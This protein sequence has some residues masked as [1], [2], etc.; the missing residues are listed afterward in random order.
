MSA[1]S[2]GCGRLGASVCAHLHVLVRTCGA[3]LR[4][5]GVV[6]VVVFVVVVVVVVVIISPS[7]GSV[8]IVVY[9]LLL[10]FGWSKPDCSKT[11]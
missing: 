10:D 1:A 8:V 3:H 5:V 4:V 7:I 6:V 11:F 2:T 9:S